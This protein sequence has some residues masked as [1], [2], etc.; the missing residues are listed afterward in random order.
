MRIMTKW[1]RLE[2]RSF[3]YKIALHLGYPHIKFDDEIK[4]IPFE[5]QA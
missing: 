3:H 2:L 4:G 5:F 1:L